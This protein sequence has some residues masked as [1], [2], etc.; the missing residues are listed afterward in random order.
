MPTCLAARADPGQFHLSPDRCDAIREHGCGAADGVERR[1]TGKARSA[2]PSRATN[3]LLDRH[4]PRESTTS[5]A[6]TTFANY[7]SLM[8]YG[9]VDGRYA[10]MK[11]DVRVLM[12]AATYAHAGTVYQSTAYKSCAVR[13][14]RRTPGGVRVSAHVPAVSPPTNRTR[15][16]GSGS[17]ATWCSQLWGA[18]T[19]IVDEVTLSGKG[20][21]EVTAVLG[22]E[23]RKSCGRRDFHKQSDPNIRIGRSDGARGSWRGLA[24]MTI[25]KESYIEGQARAG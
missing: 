22:H 1:A 24:A 19:I 18:V 8:L 7:L 6:I 16:Y 9:R 3:G 11:S 5:R 12:G 14:R 15:S 17:G 20:E 25:G 21:I 4:E 23:H 13:A 2:K 10:E